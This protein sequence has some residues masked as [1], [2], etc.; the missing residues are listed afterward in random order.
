MGD[1]ARKVVWDVVQYLRGTVLDLGCGPRK[2]L[3]H[4][5]GVDSCADTELFG[6]KIRP[7]IKVADCADL[8][9][10]GSAT[11]DSIFSSHLLEHIVDTEAALREW[12]RVLKKDGYLVLYLPHRDHYPR[13]GTPG[14]NPDH[15]HDFSPD[16]VL[17]HIASVAAASGTGVDVI[18]NQTRDGGNEYSFLLVV[19]KLGGLDWRLSC[20]NPKPDKTCCISRFGGFGDMLQMSNILP[21]LK[22]QGYTITINTTPAGQEILKN[23]PHID[24]WLI[25]DPDLVPNHELPAFWEALARRFDKFVQLSESVEG[26][27]LAMPGRA[28][29]MWP[30]GVRQVVLNKNYLE[31]TSF[32]AE[33]PYL[34]EARF[35]ATPEEAGKAQGFLTS[36]A[37]ARKPQELMIGMPNPKV[38]TIMWAL[39]GSS[40]HKFS[41]HM[42]AVIARVLLEMPEAV[43]ILAGDE[44]CQILECGWELEPRVYRESGKQTIRE[45]L[46][47]A[48]R[49]DLVLGP[50]TGVLNAVAFEPEPAKIVMLSHSSVENLTKHW[51]NTISLTPAGTSCYP[52]H[53]LHYGKSYCSTDA[54]TGAAQCQVDIT[55]GAIFD[56]IKAVYDDWKE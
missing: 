34:S 47:L 48:Q 21:E 53:M 16:D 5:L 50:E 41:P 44:A 3:P 30:Q 55:P 32:L 10:F 37:L 29:H 25:L 39:A 52:C 33:L 15:K 12:W 54:T 20:N 6:I 43:I 40:V 51:D 4:V 36:I 46:A 56:A 26:T 49:M 19:Q 1:E 13:I 17:T 9:D 22:R 8:S 38:F 11:C 45:T 7:D 31:W 27:L 28:N 24:D 23:D 35:Y 14:S 18:V 42:D 2:V